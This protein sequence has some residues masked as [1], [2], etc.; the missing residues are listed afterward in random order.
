MERIGFVARPL[1]EMK[2]VVL[3]E[4][5]HAGLVHEAVVFFGA[6]SRSRPLPPRGAESMMLGRTMKLITDMEEYVGRHA[7]SR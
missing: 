3:D 4:G 7:V 5:L 6:I 1:F 2:S